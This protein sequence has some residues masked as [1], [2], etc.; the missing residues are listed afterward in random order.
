MEPFVVLKGC[1]TVQMD[2]SL[3]FIIQTSRECQRKRT[4]EL[5]WQTWRYQGKRSAVEEGQEVERQWFVPEPVDK[6][7]E[8]LS[9]YKAL[10]LCL[11]HRNKLPCK[12]GRQYHSMLKGVW[13]IMVKVDGYMHIVLPFLVTKFACLDKRLV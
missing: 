6:E 1:C 10:F 2:G 12:E 5:F 4:Q 3:D 13:P 11:Y 9:L 7:R 8:S